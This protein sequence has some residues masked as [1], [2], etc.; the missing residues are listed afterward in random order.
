M[1]DPNSEEWDLVVVGAGPAGSMTAR[2]SARRGLR[3]LLV[4]KAPFPRWKV[5]GSCVNGAALAALEQVGLADLQGRLGAVPIRGFRLASGGRQAV[6][7]LSDGVALSRTAFDAAL[8]QEAEREGAVFV[9]GTRAVIEGVRGPCR[10]ILISKGGEQ[11]QLRA[12]VVVAATG[13][14]TVPVN[15]SSRVGVGTLLKESNSF[16]E[17]STIFM[18]CGRRGYAGLVRLEDGRLDVAAAMETNFL[19]SAGSPPR[20][21]ERLLQEAGFPSPG[22]LEAASWTGTPALNQSRRWPADDRL[23]IVGDAAGYVE[24]FTGEGIAWAL[25]SAIAVIPLIAD[26]VREW[27]PMLPSR[28]VALHRQIIRRRQFLCRWVSRGLRR[29]A[30]TSLAVRILARMPS[31]AAPAVRAINAEIG[32]NGL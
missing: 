11:Q 22:N 4:D 9:S 30:L 27:T 3:V 23:F 32:F 5:C 19:R 25:A 16:Y 12:R 13:L 28:W 6:V 14:G 8:I 26:G 18:A 21:V 10:Q 24:P 7:S 1:A 31:A 29:P 2:E 17:P 15:S 20:A